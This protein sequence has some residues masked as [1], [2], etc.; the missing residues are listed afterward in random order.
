MPITKLADKHISDKNR[1]PG[2]AWEL[3]EDDLY[4]AG[5]IGGGVG[6]LAGALIGRTGANYSMG[7]PVVRNIIKRNPRLAALKYG[8]P[9]ITG[10]L[11]ATVGEKTGRATV[12]GAHNT[13]RF[14][15]GMGRSILPEKR[16]SG[17]DSG[18]YKELVTGAGLSGA[19]SGGTGYGLAKAIQSKTPTLTGKAPKFNLRNLGRSSGIAAGTALVGSLFSRGILSAN[20]K[21]K[22]R[23]ELTNKNKYRR[24][25]NEKLTM[26]VT[27]LAKLTGEDWGKALNHSA[28]LG[29]ESG[30]QLLT[31]TARRKAMEEPTTWKRSLLTGGGIGAG[32]GAI[33]GTATKNPTAGVL[34][35]ALAGGT[36]GAATGGTA[37]MMDDFAIRDASNYLKET[38]M[39]RLRRRARSTEDV[40]RQRAGMIISDD[41]MRRNHRV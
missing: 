6:G 17:K 32:L 9:I 26:P 7:L 23:W 18:E 27:K 41:Y 16:R 25:S 37:K 11:G 10:G 15:T 31:Y 14:F 1:A 3:L 38:R 34:A 35:G 2:Q 8:V 4:G 20:E 28:R 5:V 24:N 22:H 29:E 36:M 21:N 12:K 39:D 30:E 19:V 13:D 33:V 40:D